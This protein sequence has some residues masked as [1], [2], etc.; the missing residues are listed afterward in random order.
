MKTAKRDSRYQVIYRIGGRDDF[1]W[2]LTLEAFGNYDE[3][4][5]YAQTIERRGYKTL[6]GLVWEWEAIG[7]PDTFE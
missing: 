4:Q 6:I 3:A 7:M 2:R 1:E 5:A